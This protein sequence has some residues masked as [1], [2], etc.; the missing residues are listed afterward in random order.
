MSLR[1][2]N[3]GTN[4]QNGIDPQV[5]MD[6]LDPDRT[7][8]VL[9]LQEDAPMDPDEIVIDGPATY[10]IGN[11]FKA[12]KPSV[13][14]SLSTGDETNPLEETTISFTSIKSFEPDD[15]M[16]NIPL[17]RGIKDQQDLIT[18]VETL[19][20]EAIFQKMMQD[21]KKKAV[22]LDFLRSVIADIEEAE[23]EE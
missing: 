10:S 20:Q 3:V 14:V 8:M 18:R 2:N 21:G 11:M 9:K 1:R 13:D 7:M 16:E 5:G 17:L 6:F 19:M 23:E 12:L 4:E 22:L 15:M